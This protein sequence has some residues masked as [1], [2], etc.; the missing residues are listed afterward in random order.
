MRRRQR[1]GGE[2]W[3]SGGSSSASRAACDSCASSCC[4]DLTLTDYCYALLGVTDI[5]IAFHRSC[6]LQLLTREES[7]TLGWKQ[8]A[9]L[10]A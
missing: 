3:P 1:R 4:L 8:E 2:L 7:E 5:L 9:V 6:V 10:D